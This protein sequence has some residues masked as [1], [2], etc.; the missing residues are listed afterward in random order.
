LGGILENTSEI[1]RIND[2]I[3]VMKAAAETLKEIGKDFPALR[4][5]LHRISASLHMLEINVSDLVNLD[6]R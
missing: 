2:Q 5:N 1:G 3:Q 6:R 4:C